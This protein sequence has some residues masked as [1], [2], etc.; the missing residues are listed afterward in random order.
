MPLL[1]HIVHVRYP[2]PWRERIGVKGAKPTSS[3]YHLVTA[4]IA[5]LGHTKYSF[6]GLLLHGRLAIGTLGA[7][8][9][10][11]SSHLSPIFT[12]ISFVSVGPPDRACE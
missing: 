3:V 10:R 6:K 2:T 11:L 8:A 7:L 4:Q 12:R 1:R 9:W 5:T